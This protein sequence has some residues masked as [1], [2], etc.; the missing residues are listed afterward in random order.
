MPATTSSSNPNIVIIICVALFL[1][2]V[3]VSK[4]QVPCEKCR[5]TEQYARIGRNKKLI[6]NENA[7][8]ERNGLKK[9]VEDIRGLVELIKQEDIGSEKQEI[10][11]MF[12][13]NLFIFESQLEGS[14][15]V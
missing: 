8:M 10:V 3:V 7:L 9:S 11:E 5:I 13:K 1:V 2:Y 6:E 14:Q 15:R 12:N 4:T